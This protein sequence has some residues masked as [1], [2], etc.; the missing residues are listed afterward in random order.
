MSAREQAT[1]ESSSEDNQPATNTR[2]PDSDDKIETKAAPKRGLKREGEGLVKPKSVSPSTPRTPIVFDADAVKRLD[3]VEMSAE[4]KQAY[5]KL[6]SF[7]PGMTVAQRDWPQRLRQSWERHA[8]VARSR[9]F[10]IE[11]GHYDE[12]GYV[13]ANHPN[14][15]LSRDRKAWLLLV[16]DLYRMEGH[17]VF[18]YL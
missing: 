16:A 6:R 17:R 15:D 9:Y 4:A 5:L 1:F 12:G 3:R 14:S 8:K 7:L 13:S 18:Q 11:Y 10:W 2:P